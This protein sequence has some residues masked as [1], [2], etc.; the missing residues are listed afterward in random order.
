MV[1][2]WWKE[3]HFWIKKLLNLKEFIL[4]GFKIE[5]IERKREILTKRKF[6][7]WQTLMKKILTRKIWNTLIVLKIIKLIFKALDCLINLSQNI[8]TSLSRYWVDTLFDNIQIC[9]W[10]KMMMIHPHFIHT[11]KYSSGPLIWVK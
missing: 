6:S 8:T 2:V 11:L 10:I 9:V 3:Y 4:S 7:L 1:V 5:L